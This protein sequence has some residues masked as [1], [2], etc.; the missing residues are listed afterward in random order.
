M[1]I[2]ITIK[3]RHTHDKNMY[4]IRKDGTYLM[5]PSVAKMQH[6]ILTTNRYIITNILH[7][8]LS[9]L[10]MQC[11]FVHKYIIRLCVL[12]MPYISSYANKWK[13]KVLLVIEFVVSNMRLLLL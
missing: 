12:Y 11:I 7:V 10:Y 8:T 9:H 5:A 1:Q 3:A 6:F 2:N 4:V 13:F